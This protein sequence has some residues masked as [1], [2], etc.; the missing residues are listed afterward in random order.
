LF[1]LNSTSPP[2]R[3]QQNILLASLH[4]FP[5]VRCESRFKSARPVSNLTAGWGI[6]TSS[7]TKANSDNLPDGERSSRAGNTTAESQPALPPLLQVQNKQAAT[8]WS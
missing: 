3:Q 6:V 1:H 5:L 8:R 2:G 4:A 7:Q